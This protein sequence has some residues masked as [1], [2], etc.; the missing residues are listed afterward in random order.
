MSYI[1][2]ALKRLEEKRLL[3]S[4]PHHLSP[5][6][7]FPQRKRVYFQWRYFIFFAL[8][9][10]AGILLWWAGPWQSKK[11]VAPR[12]F[13]VS[14]DET[15]GGQNEIVNDTTDEGSGP[16]MP[17][18]IIKTGHAAGPRPEE[19]ASSPIFRERPGA[20]D[21][22]GHDG[23]IIEMSELPLSIRQKLPDLSIS[24]HFYE[25]SSSSRIITVGGRTLHEGASVAPGIKLERITSDGA[26][27]SSDG[28][29]FHKSVF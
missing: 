29:R 5:G 11:S 3:E 12:T 20:E 23:K 10:N 15:I 1:L 8:L 6:H 24:G 25:S 26:I 9:L 4:G 21:T 22:A 18:R 14:R 13:E 7:S 2:E 28:Y 19:N 17:Q 27:F 16:R